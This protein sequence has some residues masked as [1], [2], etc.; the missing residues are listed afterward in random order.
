MKLVI[1][2]TLVESGIKTV[3]VTNDKYVFIAYDT[4]KI[5][6]ISLLKIYNVK[7]EHMSWFNVDG[8]YEGRNISVFLDENISIITAADEDNNSNKLY[9]FMYTSCIFESAYGTVSLHRSK[10]SAF[11]A[12]NKFLNTEWYNAYDEYL[13]HGKGMNRKDKIKYPS[14]SNVFKVGEYE[15]WCVMEQIID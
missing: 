14:L 15:G 4:K 5:D 10:R 8:D 7:W 9:A 3:T 6:L 13:Q 11:K 2:K 12:M 1:G